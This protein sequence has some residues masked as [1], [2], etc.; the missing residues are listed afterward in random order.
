MKNYIDPKDEDNKDEN[1]NEQSRVSPNEEKE[2][3]DNEVQRGLTGEI[4]DEDDVG[5][6]L[7]GNAGGNA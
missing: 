7:A 1:D 5:G 4:D 3:D 6:G 2:A